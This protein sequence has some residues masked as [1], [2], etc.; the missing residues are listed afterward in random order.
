MAFPRESMEGSLWLWYQFRLADAN[1]RCF[2]IEWLIYRK[3]KKDFGKYGIE[4]PPFEFTPIQHRNY[5]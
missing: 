5:D 1:A 4:I 3:L 2:L